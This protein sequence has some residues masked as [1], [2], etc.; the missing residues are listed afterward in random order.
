MKCTFFN[1]SIFLEG[2]QAGEAACQHAGN[3]QLRAD[4]VAKLEKQLASMKREQARLQEE[5]GAIT[6]EKRNMFVRLKQQ[7]ARCARA[8]EEAGVR[9]GKGSMLGNGTVISLLVNSVGLKQQECVAE[10]AGGTVCQGAGGSR[11][12]TGEGQILG[13]RICLP[14]VDVLCV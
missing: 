1:N 2:C 14:L 5:L 12:K 6:L 11:S 3:S 8:L 7:E 9:V 13:S 4:G 10:A